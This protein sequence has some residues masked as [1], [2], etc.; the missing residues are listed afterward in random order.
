MTSRLWRSLLHWLKRV[1][2]KGMPGWPAVRMWG[3][4]RARAETGWGLVRKR[5]RSVWLKF[6][7]GES[8][9]QFFLLSCFSVVYSQIFFFLFSDFLKKKHFIGSELWIIVLVSYPCSYKW[10]QTWW[11]RTTKI[12]S[13]N[14]SGNHSLKSVSLD[15]SHRCQP[16]WF[17]LESTG[18]KSVS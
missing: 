10:P 9:C 16:G 5:V 11:L 2:G 8:R 17:L 4:R 15:Q 7:K 14:S 13:V 3:T 18:E 6:G 12:Y 1:L